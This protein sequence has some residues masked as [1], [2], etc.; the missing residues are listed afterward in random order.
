MW[1]KS[2]FAASLFLFLVCAP[3]VAQVYTVT[4]LGPLA[5]TAINSWAQVVGN[6][7][8]RAFIWSKMG[9]MQDLGLLPGGTF[10]MAAAIND[11]G[12]VAG[13]TDGIGNV[14]FPDP[15][16]NVDCSNLAQPFVW[17]RRNGMRGLGTVA[18]YDGFPWADGGFPCFI[19]YFVTGNNARG[20]ITGYTGE[21]ASYQFAF[22]S[23]STGGMTELGGP[24]S[25]DPPISANGVS[26]TGQIV[27]QSPNAT[28]NG[29]TH[30]VSWKNAVVTD[31]GTLSGTD[32]YFECGSSANSVNDRG[33]IVGWSENCLNGNGAFHAVLWSTRGA[34]SDLGTLP[35]DT[36]SAA[37]KIN[38]F[39][40]V[41]GTS[42][43]TTVPI[44]YNAFFERWF[45]QGVAGRPFIW[46]QR[47]GMKDL[48]TLISPN[49]GWVLNTA[50]DINFWGQIVGE[51][52]LNGQPHG[53]LLTPGNPFRF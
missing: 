7:N 23:T 33:Q 6:Y 10:S 43:N 19:P 46:T 27:G 31:L 45:Y 5:P 25:S 15:A 1:T 40:L 47:S 30:A 8:G 4:D 53:F 22:I 39:G 32:P 49:S 16:D 29:I 52:M 28:V 35:G 13:T 50:T 20:R 11:F 2:A 18:F 9:G 51:G 36:L 44:L 21:Y 37:S 34:I 17:T 24:G 38:F 12:V 3:A 42:G 14:V 26:N 48:N 41:I